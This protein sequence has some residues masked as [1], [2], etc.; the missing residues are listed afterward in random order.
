MLCHQHWW[1]V[2]FLFLHCIFLLWF[3][4]QKFPTDLPLLGDP[5]EASSN[6]F[7]K[8][9]LPIFLLKPL[10]RLF[11]AFLAASPFVTFLQIGRFFLDKLKGSHPDSFLV[12]FPTFPE[13]PGS[14]HQVSIPQPPFVTKTFLLNCGR[15]IG[16]DFLR[17]LYPCACLL[18]MSKS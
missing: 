7:P 17:S 5:D 16:Y 10:K 15:L 13:V 2:I 9:R 8:S 3:I 1:L 18:E 14:L 4:S 6:T 12:P 11:R